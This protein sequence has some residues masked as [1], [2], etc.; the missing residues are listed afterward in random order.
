MSKYLKILISYFAIAILLQYI[1]A[2]GFQLYALTN[3]EIEKSYSDGQFGCL[4]LHE[5]LM[6]CTFSEFLLTS[7]FI[8]Y[9]L[10]LLTYGLPTVISIVIV[11][12]GYFAYRSA[13]AGYY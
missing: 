13:K 11:I 2:M 3:G 9:V 5:G 6:A 10:N 7:F 1:V 12:V 8:V 4:H